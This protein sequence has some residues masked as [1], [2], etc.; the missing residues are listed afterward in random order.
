M[1]KRAGLFFCDMAIIA[2]SAMLAQLLRDNFETTPDQ[3]LAF[4]PYVQVS[5]A[6]GGGC[7]LAFGLHRR[8]WRLSALGD[9]LRVVA[10]LT[11]S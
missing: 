5:T 8:V 9:Y 6:V 1:L 3:A 11:G 10:V 4:L 7:I 2:G